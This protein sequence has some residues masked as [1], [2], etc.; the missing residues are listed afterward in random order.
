M[1]LMVAVSLTVFGGWWIASK[2][3]T[4]LL[5]YAA[6][7]PQTPVMTQDDW[8]AD[9]WRRIPARRSKL[10]GELEEHFTL[11]WACSVHDIDLAL[12]ASGWRPSSPWSA[13]SAIA[14]LAP[15]SPLQDLPVLPRFDQGNKSRLAFVRWNAE[16]PA[17]REVLR[18]WDSGLRLRAGTA[19]KELPIWYGAAYREVQAHKRTI[20]NAGLLRSRV[21][22]REIMRPLPPSVSQQLRMRAAGQAPTMLAKYLP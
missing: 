9:G 3:S 15:Q 20:A 22:E 4:D 21:I 13:R 2:S 19:A 10:A 5:R 7:Q 14:W 11:Q 16:H 18:L 8:L 6:A 17:E 12:A 1:S